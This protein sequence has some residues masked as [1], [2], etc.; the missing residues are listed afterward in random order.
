[1]D[2]H[3]ADDNFIVG[4]KILYIYIYICTEKEQ[5]K[6][7]ACAEHFAAVRFVFVLAVLGLTTPT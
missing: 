5:E 7:S 6:E 1:M 2:K 3:A 4:N